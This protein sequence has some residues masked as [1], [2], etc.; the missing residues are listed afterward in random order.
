M[1]PR[2]RCCRIAVIKRRYYSTTQ[3]EKR[4]GKARRVIGS[5]MGPAETL[6]LPLG[7]GWVL[8]QP[9]MDRVVVL[10]ATGK[11]VWDLMAGGFGQQEIASA[12]VQHFGLPA[13]TVS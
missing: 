6:T 5:L 4:A 11:T 13:E 2:M 9:D 8:C 7:D 1:A 12:F 3:S 10:N